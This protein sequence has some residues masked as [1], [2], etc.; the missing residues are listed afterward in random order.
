MGTGSSTS[1]HF[2]GGPRPWILDPSNHYN[3]GR[4]LCHYAALQELTVNFSIYWC[5]RDHVYIRRCSEHQMRSR[6][7]HIGRS[8]KVRFCVQGY[9]LTSSDCPSSSRQQTLICASST[10]SDY[11]RCS[12]LLC[13]PQQVDA[14]SAARK[15]SKVPIECGKLQPSSGSWLSL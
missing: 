12:N 14:L 4:W 2:E 15:P 6:W 8:S 1:V 3:E 11:S 5:S 7:R 10:S 13:S 9:L